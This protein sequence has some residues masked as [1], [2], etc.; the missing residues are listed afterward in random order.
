[1]SLNS[2]LKNEGS[3]FVNHPHMVPRCHI[4]DAFDHTST[5]DVSGHPKMLDVDV[6]SKVR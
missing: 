6:W 4:T 2:S 1:M 3:I 5:S